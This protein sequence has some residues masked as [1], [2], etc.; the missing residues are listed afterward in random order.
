MGRFCKSKPIGTRRA[1]PAKAK[2]RKGGVRGS[3]EGRGCHRPG[4]AWQEPELPQGGGR[5][6][7]GPED[8]PSRMVPSHEP[9]SA[10]FVQ[11]SP[12]L[13]LPWLQSYTRKTLI[14]QQFYHAPASR[15]EEVCRAGRAGAGIS[16]GAAAAGPPCPVPPCPVRWRRGCSAC[17][18][19]YAPPAPGPSPPSPGER[20]RP[21]W[22][23]LRREAPIREGEW[24]PLSF[25]KDQGECVRAPAWGCVCVLSV[26]CGC[27]WSV[28]AWRYG[29][30]VCATRARPCP[31]R[32]RQP[33]L[34]E[35]REPQR[36]HPRD[37]PTF[38]PAAESPVLA[39]GDS[40]ERHCP[41][42]SKPRLLP[43][44]SMA[45]AL[46]LAGRQE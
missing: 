30:C 7:R 29:R 44:F 40:R 26:R 8:R 37:L 36:I 42:T 12:L 35:R 19:S 23:A 9:P 31:H 33:G 45:A 6:R 24:A 32:R 17:A 4:A 15:P 11:P 22:A 5:W 46:G 38:A 34:G 39:A 25:P 3:A 1:G 13:P 10:H 28:Y 21:G 43:V 16:R 18:A 14:M 20:R 2:W 41:G 27:V